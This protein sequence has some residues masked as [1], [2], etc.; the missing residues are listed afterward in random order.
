M[1]KPVHAGA[2]VLTANSIMAALGEGGRT[3]HVAE[4]LAVP[5]HERPTVRSHLLRLERAGRVQRD[6]RLSAV[7][8]MYWKPTT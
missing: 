6:A 4:R 2:A 3:H 8:C 5:L 7:N 1:A